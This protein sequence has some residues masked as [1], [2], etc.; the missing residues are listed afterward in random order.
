MNTNN[1]NQATISALNEK[2]KRAFEKSSSSAN[3]LVNL[4]SNHLKSSIGY[5]GDIKK[6]QTDNDSVDELTNFESEL[7]KQLHDYQTQIDVQVKEYQKNVGEVM[8]QDL[9]NYITTFKQN[10]DNLLTFQQDFYTRT[11][12]V[13]QDF[14][15]VNEKLSGF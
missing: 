8:N 9:T 12:E 2:L 3:M 15:I 11:Q 10:F 6:L 14:G 7:G 5:L 1:D 4:L 13:I